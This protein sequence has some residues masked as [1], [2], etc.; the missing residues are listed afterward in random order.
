VNAPVAMTG[1]GLGDRFGAKAS[2]DRI[3]ELLD[4]PCEAFGWRPDCEARDSP[5]HS[6]YYY[7][8]QA[9]MSYFFSDVVVS[10]VFLSGGSRMWDRRA[11]LS[12]DCHQII[13]IEPA[14]RRHLDNFR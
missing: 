12:S 1:L 5:L 8:L 3:G 14:T 6:R 2:I 4:Y 11:R 7:V 10:V 9:V 13:I